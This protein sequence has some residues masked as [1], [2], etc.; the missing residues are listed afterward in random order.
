MLG[1]LIFKAFLKSIHDTY[2]TGKDLSGN[3][4]SKKTFQ[5]N[6]QNNNCQQQQ[7]VIFCAGIKFKK[8]S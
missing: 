3:C 7:N 4:S 6:N 2:Q 8:A 5:L 1:V